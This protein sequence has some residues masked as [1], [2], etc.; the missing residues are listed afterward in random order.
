MRAVVVSRGRRI[1]GLGE[2]VEEAMFAHTTVGAFVTAACEANGLSVSR[3]GE[4]AVPDDGDLLVLPADLFITSTLVGALLAA[5]AA[6]GPGVH[7][8]A[9]RRTASV[10]H[11]LPLQDVTVEPL[12]EEERARA[13]AGRLAAEERAATEK[14]L[15]DAYVCLGAPAGVLDAGVLDRLRAMAKPLLVD[16]KELAIDVRLPLLPLQGTEPPRMRFPVTS[17]VAAHLRSWVHVLWLNQVAPAVL[18]NLGLRQRAV[19]TLFRILAGLSFRREAVLQKLSVIHPSARIHPTAYVE[20]SLIGPGAVVGARASVR[21]SIIAEGAEVGDHSTVLMSTVGV[22][23][24]IVPKTFLLWCCV[25]PEAVVGNQKLQVSLVGRGAHVNAWA[26]FI[27]ARFQ[28]GVKVELDGKLVDT[29]R[30]FLGSCVGHGAQ[31]AAKVLIHPGRVVPA[32]AVVVMRPDEV[33]S[34]IPPDLPPG[35]PMVRDHGTVVPMASL[36]AKSG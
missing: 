15:Y 6:A 4:G 33:I 30:S 25:Y 23:G 10:D 16:K 2:P 21:E 29:G 1:D 28:G 22:R 26:G 32:G 27:D 34:T 18:L 31:V 36:K 17:S 35:V 8:L 13:P 14:V 12:T 5:A 9:L 11:L 19:S 24:Y 3:P 20:A 7:R